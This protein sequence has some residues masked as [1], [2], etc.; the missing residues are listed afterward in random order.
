[1]KWRR[2]RRR[3]KEREGGRGEPQLS[4]ASASLPHCHPFLWACP[5]SFDLNHMWDLASGTPLQAA[6][7][8]SWRVLQLGSEGHFWPSAN[9]TVPVFQFLFTSPR[10]KLTGPV[11][12]YQLRNLLSHS[13]FLSIADHS[14]QFH[15]FLTSEFQSLGEG[16]PSFLATSFSVFVNIPPPNTHPV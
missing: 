5:N 1:M 2:R 16:L 12:P 7:I 3:K 11:A 9:P 4:K 15:P 14:E 10:K 8:A 6:C 13:H